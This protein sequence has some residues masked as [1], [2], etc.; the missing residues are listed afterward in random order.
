MCFFVWFART[1]GT[2]CVVRCWM[3]Q[4]VG[5]ANFFCVCPKALFDH[6]CSSCCE[7][8]PLPFAPLHLAE[9]VPKWVG[10]F[11]VCTLSKHSFLLLQV[12]DN[13]QSHISPAFA[14]MESCFVIYFYYLSMQHFSGL[15][16]ALL[17][18]IIPPSH[19]C[20]LTVCSLHC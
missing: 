15:L 8:E 12:E 1:L 2:L 20:F 14:G 6:F 16:P 4:T 5:D 10:T 19:G 7:D 9:A 3:S 17:L 11:W 13:G 18:Q